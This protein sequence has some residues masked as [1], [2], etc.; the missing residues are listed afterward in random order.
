HDPQPGTGRTWV[1]RSTGAGVTG[2]IW[3][4]W[5]TSWCGSGGQQFGV[6]DVAS[7]GALADGKADFYC[8][9]SAP[10]AGRT[11]VARSSGV[12]VAGDIWTP[13]LSGWCGRGEQFGLAD[14]DGDRR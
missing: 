11:W 14:F 13:W 5:L 12:G 9:D 6:A 10:G 1:A 2:D 7:P 3:T 8:H 4:P